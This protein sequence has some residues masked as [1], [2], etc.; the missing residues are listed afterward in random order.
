MNNDSPQVKME[1]KLKGAERHTKRGNVQTH[2]SQPPGPMAPSLIFKN[3]KIKNR[4]RYIFLISN[5]LE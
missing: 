4:L 3:L 2:T 1:V 5:N